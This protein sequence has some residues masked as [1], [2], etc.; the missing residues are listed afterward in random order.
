MTALFHGRIFSS[1]ESAI[2]LAKHSTRRKEI[3]SSIPFV[4]LYATLDGIIS[5]CLLEL[6][7]RISYGR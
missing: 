7:M 3:D 4:L 2:T 6:I 1:M 5:R